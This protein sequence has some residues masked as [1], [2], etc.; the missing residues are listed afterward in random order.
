MNI[1]RL[2]E[3][4][5]HSSAVTRIE[6]EEKE[7]RVSM[8]QPDKNKKQIESFILQVEA[9]TFSR[10]SRIDHRKGFHERNQTRSTSGECNRSKT[11]GRPGRGRENQG[12]YNYRPTMPGKSPA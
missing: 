3:T 2:L 10:P 9:L 12:D 7:H 6:K 5:L 1:E 11:S 8:L 4:T